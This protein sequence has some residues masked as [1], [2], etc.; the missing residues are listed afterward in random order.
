MNLAS[1]PDWDREMPLQ[2]VLHETQA[3]ACAEQGKQKHAS[4]SSSICF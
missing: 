4:T 2:H 1:A 3:A